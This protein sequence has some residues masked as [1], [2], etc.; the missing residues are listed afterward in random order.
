MNVKELFEDLADA[1][2]R[3]PIGLP[4]G[5]HVG[6]VNFYTLYTDNGAVPNAHN[7]TQDS[8][9]SGSLDTALNVTGLTDNQPYVGGA[10]TRFGM[11]YVA[12]GETPAIMDAIARSG[13]VYHKVPGGR[14][15]TFDTMEYLSPSTE[16]IG[17]VAAAPIGSSRRI[18]TRPIPGRTLLVNLAKHTFGHRWVDVVNAAANVEACAVWDGVWF[19]TQDW[20]EAEFNKRSGGGTGPSA[21]DVI[22][23]IAE[24]HATYG[25]KHAQGNE[26]LVLDLVATE[27]AGEV[28]FMPL[29]KILEEGRKIGKGTLSGLRSR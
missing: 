5:I 23:G 27:K 6:R 11:S 12:G 17:G 3:E 29:R 13:Y 20:N 9:R 10:L 14:E 1:G 15:Y 28:R 4:Q 8:I 16:F 25:Y 22:H 2:I 7:W 18:E 19:S 26:A 24:A 21:A